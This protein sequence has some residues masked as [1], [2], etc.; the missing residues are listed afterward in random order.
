MAVKTA[1]RDQE[2]V[3]RRRLRDLGV[4]EGAEFS[5][6][7]ATSTEKTIYHGLGRWPRGWELR[8]LQ[9]DASVSTPIRRVSWNGSTV[10]FAND[11]G[12]TVNLI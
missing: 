3:T 7:M 2:G 4:L 6:S 10:V 9:A 8:D 1:H 12:V 5:F 11:S